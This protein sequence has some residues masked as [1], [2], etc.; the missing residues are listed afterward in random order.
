MLWHNDLFENKVYQIETTNKNSMLLCAMKSD[1]EIEVIAPP[2]NG[3][4]PP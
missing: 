3:P 2:A 4:L 1:H